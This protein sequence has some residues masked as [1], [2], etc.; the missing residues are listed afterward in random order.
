MADQCVAI[1]NKKKNRQKKKKECLSMLLKKF[2]IQMQ[3][4]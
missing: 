1:Y 2:N 4:K 3:I